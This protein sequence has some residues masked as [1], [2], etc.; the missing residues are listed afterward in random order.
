[1]PLTNFRQM[2]LPYC[3]KKGDGGRW[4]I[5]NR[6]YMPLGF[7]E[8][9]FEVIAKIPVSYA[10]KNAGPKVMK[11]LAHHVQDNGNSVYLYDDGCLPDSSKKN[12]LQYQEKLWKLTKLRKKDS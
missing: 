12:W 1:M 11:S 6:E 3:L 8:R 5:L 4:T 9:N 7:S 10:L 2:C